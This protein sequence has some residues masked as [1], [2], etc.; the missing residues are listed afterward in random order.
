MEQIALAVQRG[1]IPD[2]EMAGVIAS[3]AEAK[4][5]QKAQRLGIPVETVD[6]RAIRTDGRRDREAFGRRLLEVLERMDA[7]V[8]TQNGWIPL[9]PTSVIQAYEGRIFNQHP[10]PPEHF[11]GKG[12]MGRAVHAS[13]LEY[14]RL[15]GCRFDTS[16]VAHHVAS[17]LDTGAVVH[18][19]KVPVLPNDTV[20]TLQARALAEEHAGQIAFLRDFV[21]GELE[22]LEPEFLVPE[23]DLPLLAE[24]KRRAIQAY[25]RG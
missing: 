16:V 25:P 10:G 2:I 22:V 8:V 9:T 11:G 21:R 18:R 15:T 17:E 12:M 13:V 19:T 14:Q 4:G 20:D 23:D 7:T 3:S 1:D 5:L 24:A 6:P